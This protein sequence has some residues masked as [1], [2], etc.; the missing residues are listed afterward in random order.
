MS[1][2]RLS[3]AVAAILAI[4]IPARLAQGQ[5]FSGL[6]NGPHPTLFIEPDTFRPDFQFFA[7]ADA[8]D[9]EVGKDRDPN[10][11]FFFTYD[12]MHVN[13]TRP[14]TRLPIYPPSS[15]P[16][17]N[18]F[19]LDRFSF[20]AEGT[21][22]WEGDF[23][24]GNRV[25]MGF[26]DCED[27]GWSIVGMFVDG[28]NEKDMIVNGDRLMGPAFSD[29]GELLDLIDPDNEADYGYQN[30]NGP[31]SPVNQVEGTT[32]LPVYTTINEATLSSFEIMRV[33]ERQT[34]HN[35][36]VLEP[37]VGMRFVKFNDKFN[38]AF[39][40]RS[41]HDLDL[42]NGDDY[43]VYHRELSK[44]ENNMLGGQLG[45]RIFKQTGHWKVSTE[46]RMFGMQNWQN[47][48]N[49][50]D[51]YIWSAGSTFIDPVGL[52]LRDPQYAR[53]EK[54]MTYD[55]GSEFVWGGELKME[56]AYQVT[57]DIGF[58]TGFYFLDLGTGV[59][60]GRDMTTSSQDVQ[61]YGMTFGFDYRR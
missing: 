7:P 54:T 26:M 21:S 25:E 39:Y 11:G 46:M 49:Q 51:N 17:A 50:T 18:P 14:E 35:G 42:V 30:I 32:D 60:R 58:R 4:G 1:T 28:P 23:T 5:T 57:R 24:W 34:F 52:I 31:G 20:V 53:R 27:R 43:E 41:D 15:A 37:M 36:A 8:T 61:L 48:S 47:F 33:L 13:V 16:P 59:G 44:F 10:H 6:Q 3:L 56:A 38:Y 29:T 45:A 19:E 2:L 55:R 22:P 12:R 9:Y 40:R